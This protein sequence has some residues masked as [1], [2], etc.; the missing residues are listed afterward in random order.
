M[1]PDHDTFAPSRASHT[2]SLATNLALFIGDSIELPLL[3]L[4]TAFN[5]LVLTGRPL[6]FSALGEE[7]G[8]VFLK[9][10]HSKENKLVVL[11]HLDSRAR[12]NHGRYCLILLNEI[13]LCIAR[14]NNE[15]CLNVLRIL[16]KKFRVDNGGQGLGRKVAAD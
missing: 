11:G 5:V 14:N 2:Q 12:H 3:F 4:S 9:C 16:H 15:M 10:R 8:A 13:L 1:Y 7:F 6:L